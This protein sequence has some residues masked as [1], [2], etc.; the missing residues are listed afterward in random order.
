MWYTR[1]VLS[2]SESAL[3]VIFMN[4][5]ISL[6]LFL[7]N[8]GDFMYERIE[9]LIGLDNLNKIRNKSVMVGGLGGV[10]GFAV[11]SLIRSGIEKIIIV[12]YDTIDITNLNRQIITNR[13]N[14]S[15]LKVDEMEK[16]ILS[17]NPSCNII[18]ININ[19][20]LQNIDVLFKYEFDYL[21]DCCDTI[22]IKQEL[23]KR[24]LDSKIVFIS[25][26]GTG[27]KLDPSLLEITDISKTSY[28][29]IAKKIRKYIR[30]NNIKGKVPV[31]YSKEQNDKF[32]GSIPSMIFVPATAGIMCSNYII[33]EIIKST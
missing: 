3:W 8:L 31:V 17:I 14:I 24:C 4:L 5:G 6:G 30:D 16:R 20:D 2:F 7:Y 9:K 29:P 27:N 10:G 33:K 26:M 18:K 32:S 19:L 13:N 23:I 12:D 15:E 1:M 11:E 22:S 21:V 28:D 25:S